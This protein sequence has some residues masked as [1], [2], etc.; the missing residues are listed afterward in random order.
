MNKPVL[1][2]DD[3]PFLRRT[4]KRALNQIG[5]EDTRILEAGNGQE[6]LRVLS[7]HEVSLI[8]LDLHMPV[9]DGETFVRVVRCEEK[10]KHVAIVVVSTEGNQECLNRLREMGIAGYLHKPFAPEDIRGLVGDALGTAS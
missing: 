10:F 3:S 7:H 8:L 5:I 1:L 4:M 6:A 9:M 2:V